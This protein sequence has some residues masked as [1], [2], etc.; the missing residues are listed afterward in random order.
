M[1]NGT[2]KVT[3]RRGLTLLDG[4]F[5]APYVDVSAHSER[6]LK[7]KDAWHSHVPAAKF[8]NLSVPP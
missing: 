1:R 2:D 8:V 4:D 5:S 7:S 6:V 3:R